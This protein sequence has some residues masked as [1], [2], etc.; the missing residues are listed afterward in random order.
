MPKTRLLSFTPIPVLRI[1]V[2]LSK[3]TLSVIDVLG[4]GDALKSMAQKN[5]GEGRV[6]RL[7][8]CVQIDLKGINRSQIDSWVAAFGVALIKVGA[9]INIVAMAAETD[10]PSEII[11]GEYLRERLTRKFLYSLPEGAYVMSNVSTTTLHL[12][13]GVDRE[14][15]WEQAVKEGIAQRTVT[16]VWKD[17]DRALARKSYPLGLSQDKRR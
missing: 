14:R 17:S 9:S 6:F 13:K 7:P 3:T 15:L 11:I 10:L 1:T 12:K 5:G 2:P 8:D 4:F 16:V